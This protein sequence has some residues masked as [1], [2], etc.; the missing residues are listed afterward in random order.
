MEKENLVRRYNL[1][2]DTDSSCS[3]TALLVAIADRIIPGIQDNLRILLVSQIDSDEDS[4]VL[5]GEDEETRHRPEY[6]VTERV[7]KT[8]RCRNKALREQEGI[9]HRSLRVYLICFLI[10]LLKAHESSSTTA[11]AK[12]VLSIQ[13]SRAKDEAEEARLIAQRRSGTRGSDARKQLL[14]AEAK[15]SEYQE[16]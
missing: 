1:S 9:N 14:K 4:F 8:D 16:R 11:I 10:V 6:T 15:L 5:A 13:L 12:A 3:L 7:V 2:V